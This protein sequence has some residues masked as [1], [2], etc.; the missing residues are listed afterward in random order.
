MLV[1]NW[2]VQALSDLS[3]SAQ[4]P[5]Q[6]HSINNQIIVRHIDYSIRRLTTIGQ[7][8]WGKPDSPRPG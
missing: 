4:I 5:E 2:V 6:R 3:G 7:N 8:S 1:D